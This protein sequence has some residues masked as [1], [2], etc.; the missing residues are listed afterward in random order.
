MRTVHNSSIVPE[1]TLNLE[2]GSEVRS[3]MG[4]WFSPLWPP[5]AL[6]TAGSA[7]VC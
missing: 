7:S 4:A 6:G 2:P 1:P 5:R 3:R